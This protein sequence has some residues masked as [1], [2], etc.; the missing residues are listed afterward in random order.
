MKKIRGYKDIL[1]VYCEL[2]KDHPEIEKVTNVKPFTQRHIVLYFK[3]GMVGDFQY[4]DETNWKLIIM[5]EFNGG[6]SDGT[7]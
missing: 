4:F 3:G 1:D 7:V 2:F 6:E 5:P